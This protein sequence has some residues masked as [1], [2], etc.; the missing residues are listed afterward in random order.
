MKR[1]ITLLALL[2]MLTGTAFAHCQIPCGIYDDAARYTTMLEHVTTIEKSMKQI[3]ALSDATSPEKNN[4]LIRWVSNKEDHANQL[5]DIVTDYFLAQRIKSGTEQ[6]EEKLKALHG[7][8]VSS[9][10]AKQ[11]VDLKQVETLRQLIT[12][13]GELYGLEETNDENHAHSQLF[14]KNPFENDFI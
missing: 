14:P 1:L 9:M 8:I 11:S 7:I 4:Q 5:I 12:I 2:S 3:A 10:K 6:Y 13:F